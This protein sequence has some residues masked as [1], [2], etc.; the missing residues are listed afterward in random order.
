MIYSAGGD[1]HIVQWQPRASSDGVVLATISEPV[2]ALAFDPLK[3]TIFAGT[4]NG[5]LFVIKNGEVKNL[6]AHNKG[7]FSILLLKTGFITTGGDGRVIVWNDANEIVRYRDVSRKSI[8]KIITA[9]KGYLLAS[10]DGNIYFIDHDLNHIKQID[11]HNSS[12]F[13]IET[14]GNDILIS[15]GRDAV[16]RVGRLSSK[17]EVETIA[18]HLLH[19]HDIKLSPDGKYLAS[20]SMDK[21][22]KIWDSDSLE[23]LK[24]LDFKKYGVHMSSVNALIW[25]NKSILISASDD[26]TLGVWMVD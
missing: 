10:S 14:L 23:L 21:T 22:I 16:L 1:G 18:A 15:G 13:A 11:A 3:N 9:N 7:L 25:I 12:V 5:N 6:V 2:Y 17:T 24:V 26:R 8:R 19:I 20:S 4:Q